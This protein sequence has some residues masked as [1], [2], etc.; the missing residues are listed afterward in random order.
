MNDELVPVGVFAR[1]GDD[2]FDGRFFDAADALEDV[3]DL[4]VFQFELMP[5]VNVLVL[6]AGAL[7]VEWTARFDAV[8]R[9]GDDADEVGGGVAFFDFDD[10]DFDAFT[11]E[12]ERDKDNETFDATDAVAT[13]RDI[14]DFEFEALAGLEQGR[15]HAPVLRVRRPICKSCD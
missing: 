12:D 9:G 11:A 15:R 4:F 5:V 7:R 2:R 3:D 6:A 1:R 8:G 10:F 13:E 14:S